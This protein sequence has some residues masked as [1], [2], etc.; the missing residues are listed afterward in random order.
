MVSG[1]HT[2][3][4]RLNANA[5]P[6]DTPTSSPLFAPTVMGNC[7]PGTCSIL[8]LVRRLRLARRRPLLPTT[9]P[10][11]C[12]AERDVSPA[13]SF[14][15]TSPDDAPVYFASIKSKLK[16]ASMRV[17]TQFPPGVP[18]VPVFNDFPPPYYE[19]GAV[20]LGDAVVPELHEFSSGFLFELPDQQ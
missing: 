5:A 6:H 19:E 17:S 10:E 9:E 2:G 18:R 3:G 20:E 15:L 14:S 13:D 8:L 11:L 7:W 12:T 1:R 4:T 16:R